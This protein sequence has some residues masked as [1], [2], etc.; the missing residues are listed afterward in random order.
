MF[1]RHNLK[2]VCAVFALCAAATLTLSSA[3]AAQTFHLV[4]SFTG[5]EGAN[6]YVGL[7]EGQMETSTAP[8]PMVGSMA[9]AMCSK[10]LQAAK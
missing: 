2:H 7:V 3:S 8:P 10:L 1:K 5:T 9:K 4:H 6:P